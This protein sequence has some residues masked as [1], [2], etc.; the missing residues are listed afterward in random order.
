MDT[1]ISL[2]IYNRPDLVKNI[3]DKLSEINFLYLFIFADG[4]KT[5]KDIYLCNKSIETVK[6]HRIYKDKSCML[7]ENK[8]NK[9]MVNQ[10]FDSLQ[11]VFTKHEKTIYIQDDQEINNSSYNFCHELLDKYKHCKDIGHINLSNLQPA[12]TF[13]NKNSY[14]FSHF[15]SVWGFGTWKRVWETYDPQMC[16]WESI[17]QNLFLNRFFPNS[18]IRKSVKKMYDL[19]CF[20]QDPWTWDYQWEF[21]C[22]NN[23][24]IAI[25]PKV[26]L[27]RD[28]GFNRDDSSHNCG[29]NPFDNSLDILE[30]PL[31]H[32]QCINVNSNFDLLVYKKAC[33]SKILVF[34]NKIKNK[35]YSYFNF[36]W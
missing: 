13:S 7:I 24:P 14:F 8:K 23:S 6:S 19:H 21:N 22:L 34:F 10:I 5:S 27:C 30:F 2:F 20:N 11:F 17:N 28:I 33:P 12:I 15:I 31:K 26:N 1:P 4:P 36:L 9:G 25:T 32:P 29:S 35:V 3:L 18:R 16:A